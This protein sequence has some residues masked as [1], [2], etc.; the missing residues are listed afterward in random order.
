MN[1]GR[2]HAVLELIK[3]DY[4]KNEILSKLQV[5]V[6]ALSASIKSASE[7][8]AVAFRNA[9][10]DL[11]GSLDASP[12]NSAPPSSL[13][14]IKEIGALDKV[15]QGLRTEIGNTLDSN[16]VTPANA[17]AELQRILEVV[18]NFNEVVLQII[19][20]FEALKI[21]YEGL[22]PGESEIGVQIPWSVV[23]SNLHGLYKNL[24]QFD[25][26]LKAFG[27]LADNNPESP[28]IKS[29]GSSL[30]QVFLTATPAIA[31]CIATAIE[32]LCALYK[33]ILEIKLLRKKVHE[34]ALP[35]SVLAPIEAH[36]KQMAEIGID[37]IVEDLVKEF[38]KNKPKER[39]NE[40]RTALRSALRFLAAQIDAGVDLEVRSEPP[41]ARDVARTE[42]ESVKSDKSKRALEEA[43]KIN[44]RIQRAGAAMRMLVRQGEPI[45]A[46]D[47]GNKKEE[48][49]TRAAK[50]AGK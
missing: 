45:L 38:G 50:S 2:L 14:I 9:I 44:A 5:A 7:D 40:L 28:A 4:D 12:I 36:E 18:A 31:L 39:L 11:Y 21:P 33:Q 48:R 24:Q 34:H 19:G 15:G 35:E 42:G 20:G 26:A 16:T 29:V 22:E 41:R 8:N 46:L 47:I 43:R 23:D 1:A 13:E 27:E 32:R 49:P 17:L 25:R 10:A 6:D 30:L 37:K 3:R